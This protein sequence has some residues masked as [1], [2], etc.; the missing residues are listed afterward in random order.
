MSK[1]VNRSINKPI[2]R[3]INKPITRSIN[4]P[5]IRSINKPIIRSIN[6]NHQLIFFGKEKVNGQEIVIEQLGS[7]ETLNGEKMFH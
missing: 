1:P 2:T 3:S 5:I 6:C 7:I 4:K